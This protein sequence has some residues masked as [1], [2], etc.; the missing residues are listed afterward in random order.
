MSQPTAQPASPATPPFAVAV[1]PPSSAVP[2]ADSAEIA[3]KVVLHSVP[4]DAY[5][6]IVEH[7]DNPGTR[8]T[9]DQGTLTIMSP[10]RRHETIK[11]RLRGM[12]EITC[13]EFQIP[14]SAGGATTHKDKRLKRGLEPDECYFIAHA[15]QMRDRDEWVFG[16]DPPPDL[17]LEV[18]ITADTEEKLPI[19]ASFRIPEVWQWSNDGLHVHH[20]Q[21]D[22]SYLEQHVSGVLPQANL[23][24]IADHVVIRGALES[25]VLSRFREAVRQSRG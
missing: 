11:S 5:E 1:S 23:Q 6:A 15:E 21:A 8:L 13:Q 22:G 25:D 3:S 17:A 7:A 19:Y 9:Y 4:W 10:S 16:V 12:V 2:V 20:L 24:M 14:Y 18:D